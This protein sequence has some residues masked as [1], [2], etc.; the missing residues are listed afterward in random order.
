MIIII[1]GGGGGAD[2]GCRGAIIDKIKLL[3]P[4]MNMSKITSGSKRIHGRSF[5]WIYSR[6]DSILIIFTHIYIYI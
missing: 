6:Y 1:V 5:R 3:R 2:G 4:V